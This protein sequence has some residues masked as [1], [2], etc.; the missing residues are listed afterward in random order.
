MDSDMIVA[1]YVRDRKTNAD[2]LVAFQAR[3]IE[4]LSYSSG[5]CRSRA[6]VSAILCIS[7]IWRLTTGGSL[8]WKGLFKLTQMW[9]ASVTSACPSCPGPR[10]SI[11][12]GHVENLLCSRYVPTVRGLERCRRVELW[13]SFLGFLSAQVLAHSKYRKHQNCQIEVRL[14]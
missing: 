14:T 4:T 3:G 7:I 8:N 9:G 13:A 2:T 12:W 11:V 6:G 1:E 5:G 10:F